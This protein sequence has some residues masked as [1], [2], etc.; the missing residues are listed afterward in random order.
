ARNIGCIL[1]AFW[2][3]SCCLLQFFNNVMW[4]DNAR[5][6]APV[7]CD[8]WVRF[9]MMSSMG[10]ISAGLVIARRISR[11]ANAT[12]ATSFD[13]NEY[14]ETLV[15]LTIGLVPPLSQL[16]FFYFMQ[17]HRFNIYEGIGCQAAIPASILAIVLSNIW[18]IILGL[19]SAIYCARTL[20]ALLIRHQE[21]TTIISSSNLNVY[22][23]YRLVAMAFIEMICDV[24]LGV[25]NLVVT[26]RDYYPWKGFNDLHFRFDR[27]DQFP[28]E[29]W[30]SL[31]SAPLMANWYHIGCALIFFGLFSF[32]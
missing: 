25:F 30:S 12:A 29:L 31:S 28:Y 8:V 22:Y 1:Y 13:S 32:T 10:I 11:I 2:S 9:E 21:I 4:R 20:R 18:Y 17:G 26:L 15:E 6:I 19:I 7:F 27:V 3:S 16:A 14:R 23:F 24:P 5:N